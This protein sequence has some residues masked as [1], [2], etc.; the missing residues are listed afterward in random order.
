[1]AELIAEKPGCRVTDLMDDLISRIA[2]LSGH[3]V[4]PPGTNTSADDVTII[5]ME[6]EAH[7]SRE[8]AVRAPRDSDDLSA[9]ITQLFHRIVTPW[10]RSG[11]SNA[12]RRVHTVLEEAILNA[13]KNAHL[14]SSEKPITVRWREGNDFHLEVIDQGDGFDP[15]SVAD[16]TTLR[17]RLSQSGRG[18]FMM[19]MVSD[20]LNW[21]DNGRHLVADFHRNPRV[22]QTEQWV[23]K[24]QHGPLWS[25]LN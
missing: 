1:M 2:G 7:G 22:A 11:L 6:I 9:W 24:H 10:E 16:P 13:W 25:L 19:R 4:A 8:E 15:R 21:Y 12:A 18:I 20:A 3:Q 17:N 14:Q 5:G 23:A